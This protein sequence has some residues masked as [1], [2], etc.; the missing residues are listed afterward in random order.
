M[1]DSEPCYYTIMY[2]M[3]QEK[4]FRVYKNSTTNDDLTHAT[5]VYRSQDG[6]W[7]T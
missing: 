4:Y 6:G 3:K 2:Q 7:L 5:Y 1:L